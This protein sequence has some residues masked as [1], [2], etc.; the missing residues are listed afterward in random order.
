[1]IVL[2]ENEVREGPSHEALVAAWRILL[3]AAAQ[4]EERAAGRA[5]T[6]ESEA[7]AAM[8][9]PVAAA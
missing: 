6:E 2:A 1:M 9:V 5:N 8:S 4:M 7:Q 3:A